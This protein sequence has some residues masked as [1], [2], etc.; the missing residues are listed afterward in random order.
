MRACQACGVALTKHRADARYCGNVCR[1]RAHR[2]SEVAN[3]VPAKACG[4]VLRAE[5]SV[6]GTPIPS[7]VTSS[8]FV[9]RE[10]DNPR[11][12]RASKSLDPRIVPDSKWPGMFRIRLRDGSLSDMANL[13][14]IKD[15][16]RHD[17]IT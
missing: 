2:R 9:A 12:L 6:S 10:T 14:R 3:G 7:A 15:A 4:S 13:T 16:L 11:I 17:T 1:L 5:L 8:P